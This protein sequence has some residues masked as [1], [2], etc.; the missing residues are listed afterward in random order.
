MY[1]VLTSVVAVLLVALSGGLILWHLRARRMNPHDELPEAEQEFARRQFRRR[2]QTSVMIGIVG[3]A[4]F[5]G[6]FVGRLWLGAYWLG[7]ILVLFWVVLLALGDALASQ[8]HFRRLHRQNMAEQVKLQA[9]IRRKGHTNGH[10][11]P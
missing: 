1:S 5:G 9:E 2:L 6:Q 8:Q 11:A 10:V 3:A 7:I 4:M